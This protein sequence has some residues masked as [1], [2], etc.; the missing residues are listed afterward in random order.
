MGTKI[1]V[2]KWSRMLGPKEVEQL[3]YATSHHARSADLMENASMER[4]L[5]T[6]PGQYAQ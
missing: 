5:C 2:Y 4:E 3:T 1:R 6:F